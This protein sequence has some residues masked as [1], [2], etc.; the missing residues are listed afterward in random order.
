M[1]SYDIRL[2][3]NTFETRFE[4]NNNIL[5]PWT[6]NKW[7]SRKM[8]RKIRKNEFH[9]CSITFYRDRKKARRFILNYTQLSKR[10][11]MS[12]IYAKE[13]NIPRRSNIVRAQCIVRE[14]CYF[15]LSMN[16]IPR[17]RFTRNNINAEY[18][19]RSVVYEIFRP[20]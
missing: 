6:R 16:D 12:T 4:N 9:G 7:A 14:S 1:Y 10:T 20:W 19:V 18:F 17:T 13:R 2:H 8:E 11:A 15:Y 3:I 5:A